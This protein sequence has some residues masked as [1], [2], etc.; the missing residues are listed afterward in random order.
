MTTNAPN[1]APK[2]PPP[3]NTIKIDGRE[4]PFEPGD[5]IIRAA[6]RQGI[7]IP[8][9][10]W[11]PGLSIAAN[12]RMCLV[13]ILPAPNQRAMMLDVLEWDATKQDY[14]PKKKPKLQPA[15]QIAVSENMEVLSDSSKNVEEARH[16]VQEFLLLNHPVD[17]PICDQA[18][19]CKL[20]DYWLEHMKT[21]KRRVDEPVH[22]PKAV[23]FGPSIVYDAERC[24]MCTR[25]VR[26]CEE[27]AKD[28]V[29]SLRQRGN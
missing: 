12:C 17:C 28:P 22:K 26:F 2:P 14:V 7:D 19:E 20:Q 25:C 13:E 27:V 8:H 1:E 15:C 3:P 4:I 29:L 16:H 24:V 5:T 9:Y 18:G 21:Q 6:W 10:C 11:H 23:V